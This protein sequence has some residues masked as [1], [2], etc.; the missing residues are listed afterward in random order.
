MK[1][2]KEKAKRSKTYEV[3]FWYLNFIGDVDMGYDYDRVKVKA[4]SPR[5]AI[6]KAEQLAPRGAKKFEII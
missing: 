3:E 5:Q 4:I 2:V 6:L 1:I